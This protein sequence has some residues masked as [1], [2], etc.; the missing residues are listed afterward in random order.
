M[1]VPSIEY[2]V[3]GGHLRVQHRTISILA[4]AYCS[5]TH[6]MVHT[7]FQIIQ[8]LFKCWY[9]GIPNFFAY[10]SHISKRHFMINSQFF[11]V[12]NALIWPPCHPIP[13]KV[14]KAVPWTQATSQL[15]QIQWNYLRKP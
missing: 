12:N 8:K 13:S 9:L 14:A 2:G 10:F 11:L 15:L 5:V 1:H 3:P 7:S 4:V 6:L